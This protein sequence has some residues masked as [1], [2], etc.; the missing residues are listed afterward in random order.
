MELK[1]KYNG[2]KGTFIFFLGIISLK[3]YRKIRSAA[4]INFYKY[5]ELDTKLS[6]NIYKLCNNN[7]L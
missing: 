1:M 4:L 3:G 6:I 7:Y 5:A 2:N